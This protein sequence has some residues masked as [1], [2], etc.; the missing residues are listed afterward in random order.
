[1]RALDRIP[2]PLLA[3]A[4]VF[5]VQFGS[6]TARTFFGETGPVGAAAL[7]LVFASVVML[8]VV[9]PRVRAW[10]RR[11]WLTVV[12]LGIALGGMNTLIYLAIQHVPI[13]VAVTVEFLGPL[14]V[15]LAQTRRA[16]DAAWALLALAGVVL[17]GLE[18]L[19]SRG[20][21][22]LDLAG[23]GLA[24][25]AAVFWAGYI[26]TSASLGSRATGLDPLAVS[27]LVAT[28]VVL[29]FGAAPAGS[30]VAADP[31][32]LLVF[33]GVGLAT[34]V[35]PYS[36]EF[37][38]LRR[39]PTRVFG[40]LS[41]LGPAIAALAGL[42]VLHQALGWRQWLAL[43]LVTAASVGVTVLA[44]R[45]GGPSAP[46]ATPGRDARARRLGATCESAGCEA[47]R[48]GAL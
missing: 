21:G 14:G 1:M 32:L 22:A 12:A 44:R 28:L 46:G 18:A 7:R 26:V 41:S 20:P 6:A 48:T 10:N 4:A 43:A 38:A 45:P 13:G 40:V 31:R 42:V 15:A 17:L 5:S 19:E 9:R 11:T 29:P 27:M 25:L 39:I 30:A 34:S 8:L 35:I 24:A 36:L 37:A 23:L 16:V 3:V 33:L 47:R 2:A